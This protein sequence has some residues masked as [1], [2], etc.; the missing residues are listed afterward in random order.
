MSLTAD[1]IVQ[2]AGGALLAQKNLLLNARNFTNRGSLDS[3]ALT[4][5][6]AGNIDNQTS[7][8]I[9]TR[10]GLNSTSDSFNNDG[11]DRGLRDGRSRADRPDQ[12]RQPAG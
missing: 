12:H 7:G 10:N 2:Q 3:D 1:N 5:A 11:S 9:T 8:K 6:I 4:L